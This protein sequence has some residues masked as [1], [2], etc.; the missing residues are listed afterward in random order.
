M[1]VTA[2][3]TSDEDLMR[4]WQCG[5]ASA[6]EVLYRRYRGSLYRFLVRQAGGEATGEELYHDVWMTLVRG[7]DQWAPSAALKTY[8]YRIAHSRLVDHY[9]HAGR[10]SHPL[11]V[12]MD[13]DGAPEMADICARA[14]AGWERA[15]TADA[16]HRC[17]ATLPPAQREAFLLKEESELGL[18]EIAAVTGAEAETIKSRVRYAITRL[19]RC[20]EG[21]L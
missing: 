6:F 8:L 4:A 12:S 21:W 18:A 20:L 7:R 17:L 5:D 2:E 1:S 19:R 3:A 15:S 14:E 11:D 13:A 9:R 10:R 16:V